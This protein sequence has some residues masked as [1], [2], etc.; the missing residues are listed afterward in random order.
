MYINVIARSLLLTATSVL[1]AFILRSGDY[2]TIIN[3]GL[4]IV[5]QTFLLIFYLNKVNRELSYFFSSVINEDSSLSFTKGYKGRSFEK[6]YKSMEYVNEQIRKMRIENVNQNQ[7]FFTLSEHV[8][9]GLLSFDEEGQVELFNDAAQKLLNITNLFNIQELNK[10]H[11][12]FPNILKT[13]KPGKQKLVRIKI[14]N[15]FLLL[16]AKATLLKIRGE[17]IKLVS[18]QNIKNELEEN[19]LESWQKLIRVLTHEIMNS[20]APIASTITTLTCFFR[21]EENNIPVEVEE[22]DENIIR[23]TLN[24]LNIIGDRSEGLI[25]FINKYRSLTALPK[26]VMEDFKLNVMFN[27]I[28]LLLEEEI[29]RNNIN[30]IIIADQVDL[31]LKADK[32][33]VEQ[34]LINL[35]KNSISAFEK[36][37]KEKL[38]DIKQTGK[39]IKLEAFKNKEERVNICVSDN[40]CGIAEDIVDQ[41][42]IP[43]FTTR[44]NGS[45]IGLSLSRQ[46][47]RLHAGTISVQSEPGEET[48]FI[49]KF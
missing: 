37:D 38:I 16:S 5:I 19:E 28:H 49:L 20:I 18:L 40:G 26:P 12:G 4:L 30:F 3:L 6:L 35:V 9:I 2:F 24:G 7:Y 39:F 25:N 42:F 29:K 43:F 32:K 36:P 17:T 22:I 1:F 14:G 8:G 45:G 46:I 48:R 23:H 31:M 21:K 15:E 41:I 10:I 27:N 47:M 33:L 44:E 11:N 13:I 34:I